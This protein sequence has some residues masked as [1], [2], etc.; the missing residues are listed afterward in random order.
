MKN[1]CRYIGI[2]TLLFLFSNKAQAQ[3]DAAGIDKTFLTEKWWSGDKTKNKN[4]NLLSQFFAEDGTYLVSKGAKG[5]WVIEGSEL[6]ISQG[7]MKYTYKVIKLTEKEFEFET[8]DQHMYF[9]KDD[10]IKK[11]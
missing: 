6:K 2:I 4:K 7:V 5:K 10:K 11:K 9:L 8:M 1:T 3:A